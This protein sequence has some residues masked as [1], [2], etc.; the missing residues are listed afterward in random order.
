MCMSLLP[1]SLEEGGLVTAS[2]VPSL[3]TP[4]PPFGR[5]L[6]PPF[7]LHLPGVEYIVSDKIF[8]QLPEEEKRLWHSH[9][10]EVREREREWRGK[11]K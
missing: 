10:H 5:L 1:Y 9:Y 6:P 3:P 8:A 11:G 7:P 4:P 2:L